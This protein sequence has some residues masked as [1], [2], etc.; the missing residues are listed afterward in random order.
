M[1]FE[2]G[3]E[4]VDEH[5]GR[6]QTGELDDSARPHLDARPE[7][8]PFELQAFCGD[9]LAELSRSDV[10]AFRSQ[11]FEKL[12]WDK[13]HL[14]QIGESRLPSGEIPVFDE[15]AGVRIPFDAAA[16]DQQ[17]TSL[18]PFAET[19]RSI[20][21]HRHD[22]ALQHEIWQRHVRLSIGVRLGPPIGIQKGL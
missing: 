1:P 14:A 2:A 16:L 20:S 19:V 5:A 7:R 9:V 17:N 3:P 10:I 12:G 22:A 15:S 8:H 6:A 18:R 21:G 4:A 13:V 11:S